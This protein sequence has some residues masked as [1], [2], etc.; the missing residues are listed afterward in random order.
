MSVRFSPTLVL[1]IGGSLRPP[2]IPLRPPLRVELAL[3][4]DVLREVLAP[5]RH[6]FLVH[7]GDAETVL[8]PPVVATI[9]VGAKPRQRREL[10]RPL[11][12]RHVGEVQCS[13][14]PP[15]A[16]RRRVVR[17]GGLVGGVEIA[18][19][20]AH[21]A[22]PDLGGEAAGGARADAAVSPSFPATRRHGGA[23]AA[24]RKRAG[25]E[26]WRGTERGESGGKAQ[27]GG[28]ALD[29]I[30]RAGR[31]APKLAHARP[32]F[33]ARARSFPDVSAISTL[34][35]TVIFILY[36]IFNIYLYFLYCLLFFSILFFL[37]I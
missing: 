15:E 27:S 37:A 31:R 24:R 22:E 23:A 7:L 21:P 36:F 2:L 32:L 4:D 11:P 5:Q 33:P 29:F 17:A 35:S 34:F 6:G 1:A 25:R 30:K 19:A 26:R 10:L 8:P 16:P 3:V 18:E 12:R 20:E 13:M 28:R 14:R 9:L